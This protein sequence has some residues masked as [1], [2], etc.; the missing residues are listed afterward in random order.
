VGA[1]PA[2][3]TAA[4]HLAETGSLD[5]LVVDRSPF[6]RHKACGGALVGSRD[7]PDLFP[8]YAEIQDQLRSRSVERVQFR[9]DR[10]PWWEGGDTHFFDQVRRD[11]FDDLL[12]RAALARPG[13]SFRVFHVRSVERRRDGM[14]ELSD[15]SNSLIA[16]AVIGADG[17]SS[18]VS[19]AV[20]NPKRSVNQRGTCL[21]HH[22]AC[23]RSHDDAVIF[24]LWGGDPGYCYLFPTPDGYCAGAGFLGDA[25]KRTR[26]HL[27]RLMTHCVEEGLLPEQHD[28]CRTLAGIAPATVPGLIADGNILLVGDAAGLLNQLSG[29]GI[30]YAMRSGQ[31]AA[32]VLT[33]SLERCASRYR[34]A[35]QP[36]V[37]E[38]TY[39]RTLRPRLFRGVLQGYFGLTTFGRVFGLDGPLRR[40]FVNRLFRRTVLPARSKYRTLA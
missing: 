9:V 3:S 13:V 8:N 28:V 10:S 23:E 22:I 34:H 40:P 21:I 2:G 25:G 11:E 38:V 20:G 17:A 37:K 39:L 12:L 6:P 1:G 31:I 36:L 5:V 33:E 24:Y 27:E 18:K 30:Y 14:I 16:R 29:E 19:R 35:I 15:G 32:S 26:A 7:W 4:Y